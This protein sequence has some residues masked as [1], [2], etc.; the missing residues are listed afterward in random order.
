LEVEFFKHDIREGDTGGDPLQM[1]GGLDLVVSNPPYIPLGEKEG[2]DPNVRDHDPHEALFV[3]DDN[4]LLYYS[5]IAN[6]EKSILPKG[7]RLYLE[8]HENF[9]ADV[10]SLLEKSGYGD[11]IIKKDING[12]DRMVRARRN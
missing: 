6:C 5:H 1:L 8:I 3:P 9:A 7:G 10:S 4:P 12:K 2:L 11:I